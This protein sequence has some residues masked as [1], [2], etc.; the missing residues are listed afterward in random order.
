MAARSA[1]ALR[2]KRTSATMAGEELPDR[3]IGGRVERR[4]VPAFQLG[5]LVLGEGGGRGVAG[6][7][8]GHHVGE[9]ILVRRREDG[10]GL[11]EDDVETGVHAG[12]IAGRRRVRQLCE[13]GRSG[14]ITHPT[15]ATLPPRQERQFVLNRN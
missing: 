15:L 12:I 9:P 1:S 10:A 6:D 4:L 7:I 2:G 5:L 8:G 13:V 14:W 3:V 11:V